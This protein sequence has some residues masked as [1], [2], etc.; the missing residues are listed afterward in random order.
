[1]YGVLDL[2]VPRLPVDAP[3]HLL[4]IGEPDDLVEGIG[5]GIDLF[6]CAVP[7]RLARHGMALAPLPDSRFRFDV[8]RASHALSEEPLVAGCACPACTDHTR[9]YLHYLVRARELTGVRLLCLHN[10]SYLERLV[11]GAREA[12]GEG[13]YEAYRG[14][15]LDGATPWSA[16]SVAY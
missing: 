15:V 4:G 2:T 6:D 7:T 5:R 9:A 3:K 13:R 1:M 12:I 10:V 14:A 16:A 8:A 11:A